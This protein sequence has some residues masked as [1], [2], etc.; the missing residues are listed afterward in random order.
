MRTIT[1]TQ[2][3]E[4]SP[5]HT[6]LE[7]AREV[8]RAGLPP[9]AV[10]ILGLVWGANAENLGDRWAGRVHIEPLTAVLGLPPGDVSRMVKGL[11]SLRLV[12]TD[13]EGWISAL[14]CTLETLHPLHS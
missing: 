4:S 12:D 11:E 10:A 2:R 14:P 7:A 1:L 6:S 8:R 9:G 3:G 5:L 13:D